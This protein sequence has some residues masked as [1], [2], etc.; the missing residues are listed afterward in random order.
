[1]QKDIHAIVDEV[2]R[3]IAED[4]QCKLNAYISHVSASIKQATENALITVNVGNSDGHV[5][6][7]VKDWREQWKHEAAMRVG[8]AARVILQK[9]LINRQGEA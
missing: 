2:I 5:Q 1:M 6:K 4:E 9:M 8:E 3:D 7:I